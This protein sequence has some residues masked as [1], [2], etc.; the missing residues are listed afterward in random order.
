MLVLLLLLT[1]SLSGADEPP[2]PRFHPDTFEDEYISDPLLPP[3]PGAL[4][5]FTIF[6]IDGVV[7]VRPSAKAIALGYDQGVLD[8]TV[9]AVLESR[10]GTYDFVAVTHTTE[11]PYT[12][13]AGAF[14]RA[15][16]NAE[17]RGVGRV[18]QTA[19]SVDTR[20]VLWLNHL[21]YWTFDLKVRDWV[22]CHELSHYWLAFAKLPD[23]EHRTDLLGRQTAHWSYW[24]QT[25]NSPIEGNAWVDNGDGTF[26][27]D[28]EVEPRFSTLDLY[29]MGLAGPDEVEPFFYI[30]DPQSSDRT[31]VSGPEHL[32][33]D[34]YD[35]VQPVTVA[36]TRVDVDI[37][38]IIA[39]NGARRPVVG[40][41]PTSFNIL[42]VLV[43]APGETLEEEHLQTF[44]DHRSGWAQ[45]WST[46][47]GGGSSITFDIAEDWGPPETSGPALVPRGAW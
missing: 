17:L 19:L 24:T 35:D 32:Y 15:Y 38:D 22:L 5:E 28:L 39:A 42:P 46:M 16:N 47:T 36:G 7:V 41:A 21:D 27:T 31:A 3:P 34:Y 8:D 29:L 11:L 4:D 1:S 6:D 33:K 2:I 20:S 10:E 26:T 14:H 44:A 40:E 23:P 30:D 43:L 13:T 25:P 18:P 45:A 9:L 12:F 37:D